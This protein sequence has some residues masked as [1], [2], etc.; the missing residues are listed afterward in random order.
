MNQKAFLKNHIK[1]NNMIQKIKDVIHFYVDLFKEGFMD[2]K[3]RSEIRSPLKSAEKLVKKAEKNTTR[4]A[5]YDE[6]IRDPVIKKAEKSMGKK[7]PKPP[8]SI[9]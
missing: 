3:M 9:K 4:L 8:K 6:K 2:K 7:L 1:K 5:N